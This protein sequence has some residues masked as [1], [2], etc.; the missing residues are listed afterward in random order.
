MIKNYLIYSITMIVS[1]TYAYWVCSKKINN[2]LHKN[3]NLIYLYFCLNFSLSIGLFALMM[4]EI[5]YFKQ[6]QNDLQE[7]MWLFEI[8]CLNLNILFLG[9]ILMILQLVKIFSSIKLKNFFIIS[10][11]SVYFYVLIRSL[12]KEADLMEA[13]KH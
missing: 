10:M 4:Q 8:K 1:S 12:Y 5:I 11:I 7:K 3:N 13:F 2:S 9:P 6:T